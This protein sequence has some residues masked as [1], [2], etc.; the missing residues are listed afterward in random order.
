MRIS[1]FGLGYVGC[2]SLAC[3]AKN[4]HHVIGTDVNQIKVDLINSGKPTIIENEI[5]SLI[6][7]GFSTGQYRS[8]DKFQE[9]VLNTDVSIICV[10]HLPVKEAI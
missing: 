1:I 10:G 8:N 6:S 4:G 3:L 7:N 5:S 2:V 9:A